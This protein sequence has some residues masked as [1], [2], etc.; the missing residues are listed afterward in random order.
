[1]AT[2]GS[3][4]RERGSTVITGEVNPCDGLTERNAPGHH[5][6][7]GAGDHQGRSQPGDGRPRSEPPVNPAHRTARGGENRRGPRERRLEPYGDAPEQVHGAGDQE[8]HLANQ[9]RRGEPAEDPGK[10]VPGR[11][12][13]VRY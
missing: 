12:D 3:P 8:R 1:M 9:P 5:D 10:P 13:T 11:L 7:G 6:D 4:A 2:G